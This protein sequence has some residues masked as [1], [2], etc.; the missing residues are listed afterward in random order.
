MT[1][2]FTYAAAA[3][4]LIVG[5]YMAATNQSD[6]NERLVREL[7]RA[8]F[9]DLR[10]DGVLRD[11]NRARI[12]IGLAPICIELPQPADCVRIVVVRM[13]EPTAGPKSI[14]IRGL[15]NSV[16]WNALAFPPRLILIDSK[17]LDVF[18][19]SSI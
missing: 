15:P 4:L 2:Y 19:S 6:M 7:V 11:Y 9:V 17:L 5:V 16:A 3:V 12:Q 18:G 10:Y 14:R 1:R 13:P 8:G